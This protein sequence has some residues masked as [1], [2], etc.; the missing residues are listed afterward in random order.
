[1]YGA[2][3]I[4]PEKRHRSFESLA[5]SGCRLSRRGLFFG[6]FPRGNCADDGKLAAEINLVLGVVV[7]RKAFVE[8]PFDTT[9]AHHPGQRFECQ[10][11]RSWPGHRR[12]RGSCERM[13]AWRLRLSIQ[14]QMRAAVV[15]RPIWFGPRKAHSQTVKC[16]HPSLRVAAMTSRSRV[17]FL[18]I[19]S[20]QNCLLVDG[21]R[22]RL[23][24]CPCQKQP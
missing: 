5:S 12:C 8:Q 7:W 16:R 20:A 21:I 9:V 17:W 23:Q 19:F 13:T 15:S 4:K 14:S 24:S 10:F 2:L 1:M 22:K 6:K 11:V 3:G 18:A